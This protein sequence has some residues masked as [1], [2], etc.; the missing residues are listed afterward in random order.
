MGH[1]KSDSVHEAKTN[2]MVRF[3]SSRACLRPTYISISRIFS[4]AK[5]SQQVERERNL[6]LGWMG[7]AQFLSSDFGLSR[8]KM[9][10]FLC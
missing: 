4:K 2:L 5:F 3:D 9:F 8:L 1:N 7:F 6:L 10:L